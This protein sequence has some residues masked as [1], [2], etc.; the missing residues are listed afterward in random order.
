MDD[1]PGRQRWLAWVSFDGTGFSGFQRQDGPRTVAGELEAGWQRWLGESVTVRSSSRT[2]AG[3]H[4]RR[5]P[6]VVQ[7]ER[8]LP[9]KAIVLGWNHA[10]P[11]DLAIQQA[12]AV[13]DDF[14]VRHDAIGK[15]YVYRIW[16]ARARDPRRRL[17]HWHVPVALDVERMAHA[18]TAFVGD[19]D[20]SAFRAA[21]CSALS[22]RRTMRGVEIRV[23]AP[24][25]EVVVEGNAFLQNMVR[26]MVGTLVAIG[27]GTLAE[28]AVVRALGSGARQDAGLTAPALGLELDEV[29][30]GPHGARQGLEH[31][32]LLAR[33]EGLEPS[34]D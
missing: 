32:Q 8:Q 2:D 30:Y 6:V 19:H 26:I 23:R 28:D 16:N 22:T 9:A 20:F 27:R 4:A 3:V 14:H 11:E 17:D 13:A 24:V 15:R 7:T 31:K 10:L 1:A 5:M 29:F 18:A 21:T 33:L 12:E 25:I 34:A